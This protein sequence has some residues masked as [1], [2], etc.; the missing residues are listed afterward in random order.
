MGRARTNRAAGTQTA[1][2]PAP[3]TSVKTRVTAGAE[4]LML[5]H[6]GSVES[7]LGNSIPGK[8]DARE[9]LRATVAPVSKP[10]LARA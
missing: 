5:E 10:K 3:G 7:A 9:Q 1:L 2:T 8:A 4:R 6:V